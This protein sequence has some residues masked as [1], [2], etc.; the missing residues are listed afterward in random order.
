MTRNTGVYR[1]FATAFL[2][3]GILS[4]PQTSAQQQ[5][6]TPSSSSESSNATPKAD[7]QDPT[8]GKSKLE[9]ETG[10]IN[11]RIF[12][13]LPNYGTVEN[14]NEL[15]RLSTGQKFRL[16]T[17]GVFDWAS[18]PFN[19]TLAAIAQ[20]KNDPPSWGQGWV[21]MPSASANRSPTTASAHT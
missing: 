9:K 13:V 4:V 21:L 8:T 3:A 12:D 17:A 1:Y 7:T 5:A 16:A 20:A 18:Y 11:D 19:A 2:F 15:P 6:A 10:T 14:A